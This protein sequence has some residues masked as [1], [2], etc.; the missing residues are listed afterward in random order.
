[1]KKTITALAAIALAGSLYAAVESVNIVGYNTV[2]IDKEWT[3]IGVNFENVG[4]GEITINDA[5]PFAEGMTKGNTTGTADNIQIQNVSGTYDT[6]YMSNGKNVKGNTVTGLEGNWAA[7]SQYTPTEATIGSGT[8]MWYGAKNIATPFNITVAGQVLVSAT[9]DTSINLVAKHIANPYATDLALNDGIPY[10]EGMTKGN[11]T[12]SADNIQI[13]NDSGTYD[14]YY[15]S[16]GKNVK[17]NTVTGLEGKWAAASQYTPADS[18][19]VIPVGKGA[20]YLRRGE[21]NFDITI[22]RPFAL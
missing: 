3:I 13:Q 4:S 7:A 22:T 18:S 6:Y 17:G 16:N 5:I 15:M 21:S 9:A 8:A 14:T 20:W 10:T 1:M 11:T 2:T 12:G 19:A